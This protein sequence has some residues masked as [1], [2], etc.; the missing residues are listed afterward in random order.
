[1]AAALRDGNHFREAAVLFEKKLNQPLAAAQCLQ[2]GGLFTEAIAI[3]ER[4]EAWETIG[5][6]YDQLQQTDAAAAAW[7][8]A[9][10]KRLRGDDSL[11]AAKLLEEKLKLPEE[12]YDVLRSAWPGKLQASLC[13][14]A[15]FDLLSRLGEHE[16]AIKQ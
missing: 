2:R 3:Y 10:D 6:I 15:S 8:K 11:G 13:L 16:R 1:A 4:L 9:V 5:E 14:R 7:R 12:A